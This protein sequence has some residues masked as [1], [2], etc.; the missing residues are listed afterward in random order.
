MVIEVAVGTAASN[1]S[2]PPGVV[3]AERWYLLAPPGFHE[4]VTA[5]SVRLVPGIWL[6]KCAGLRTIC[7]VN[8]PVVYA[9]FVVASTMYVPEVGNSTEVPSDGIR[10]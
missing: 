7:N 6:T 3:P 1:K 9:L 5:V 8:C 10:E 4:K 2:V